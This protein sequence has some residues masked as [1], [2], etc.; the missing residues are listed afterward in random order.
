MKVLEE[1]DNKYWVSREQCIYCGTRVEINE[2]DI[3]VSISR[4]FEGDEYH[5]YWFECPSCEKDVPVCYTHIVEPI[6][7]LVIARKKVEDTLIKVKKN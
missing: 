6:R 7:E 5:D 2:D 1:N 3:K 4:D